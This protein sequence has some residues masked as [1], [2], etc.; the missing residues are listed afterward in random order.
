MQKTELA[1]SDQLTGSHVTQLSK[2]GV[3]V[4]M[5]TTQFP[6]VIVAP[7]PRSRSSK[8]HSQLTYMRHGCCIQTFTKLHVCVGQSML[9]MTVFLI[10]KTT[11]KDFF[12]K[13]STNI[14]T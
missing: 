8:S 6:D 7:V 5:V 12:V 9:R 2:V 1:Q 11:S 13:T 14:K 3:V 4:V 10:K